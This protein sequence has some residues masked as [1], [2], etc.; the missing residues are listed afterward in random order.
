MI[1][2][3]TLSS[4]VAGD[5]TAPKAEGASRFGGF[6][7]RHHAS[8]RTGEF[9]RFVVL[10]LGMSIPLVF[11][12]GVVLAP[13]E[14]LDVLLVAL[15]ALNTLWVAAAAAT[16]LIGLRADDTGRPGSAPRGWKPKKHTAVLFLIC[17]EDPDGVA[18]RMAAMHRDVARSGVTETTD[19]WL[20]SDTSGERVPAEEHFVMPLVEAGKIRYRRRTRNTRRK[21]GN[22]ADWIRA[23]GDRYE[24]MVVMD[25]DSAMTAERLNDLR[26]HMERT[27]CLGLLQSGIALRPGRTRFARLQ[28]LSA[29]LTGPVF[30]RGLQ[31]WSGH[32]GNYWGH[33][34]LIRVAAFRDA[35][36]L[37]AL[38]GP[39][40]YGGDYLSHDFIEAAALVRTGWRVEVAPE[41]RGSSEAGPEDLTTFHRRDRRWCQGNLQHIRPLFS[42]RLHPISRIHLACGIQSYLSSPIWLV[43]ILLFLLA[44]MAP[45]AVP[46][47][48]GALALLLVPKLAALIRFWRRTS[49][50]PRRRVFLRATG[51]ELLLSTLLSPLVMVRQML[52][53]CAVCMGRDCGWKRPAERPR[54]SLPSGVLEL[55]AGLALVAV[56]ILGGESAWQA[57]WLTLIAGPLL[58]APWL[59]PWLDARKES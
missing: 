14:A 51:A 27:P 49:R 18:R 55:T 9:R 50:A 15:F 40:P 36:H 29:R 6:G 4:T 22:L 54:L 31:A 26:H 11:G 16:S 48:S 45:G 57:L 44:G 2:A 58:A 33:N 3:V 25:A 21:P 43:L 38:S 19:I 12:L 39:A 46:V 52:A 20:L 23:Q 30:A 13:L 1:N 5:D 56:A 53:V 8:M 28:R 59:V 17:G 37:P 41:T 42:E 35:M 32:A 7:L 47:L 10:T 34:A 24:I